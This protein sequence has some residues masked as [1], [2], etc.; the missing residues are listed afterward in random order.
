MSPSNA[1]LTQYQQDLWSMGGERSI[2]RIYEM[3]FDKLIS[4]INNL[5]SKW[6]E[7]SKKVLAKAAEL[8]REAARERSPYL[9]G[10]LRGAHFSDVEETT[11]GP[12]GLVAISDAWHPIMGGYAS[13]YGPRIH[14]ED[15]PWFA[16]T[17][18]Q[19]SSRIMS[20][21]GADMKSIY[22]E[23]LG[24]LPSYVF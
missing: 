21:V 13:D 22:A 16:W 4:D 18:E 9:Y 7:E 15:R 19:E 5:E 3:G 20:E 6:D 14:S 24:G 8:F 11:D 2:I 10:I 17:V 1:P 12:V 23:H